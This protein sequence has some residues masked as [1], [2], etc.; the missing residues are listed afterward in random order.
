MELANR[1]AYEQRAVTSA[2]QRIA[3]IEQ[4]A[5]ELQQTNMSL[6]HQVDTLQVSLVILLSIMSVDLTERNFGHV[7]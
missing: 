3:K 7:C 4:T 2:D 1:L 5:D 6:E